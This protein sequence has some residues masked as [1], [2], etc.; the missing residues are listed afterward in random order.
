MA[1]KEPNPDNGEIKLT[2]WSVWPTWESWTWPGHEG[3][4]IQVEVYSKYPSVRLFLN[5]KLVGE[6]LTSIEQENKTTFTIPYT[7]GTLK[8][9][10]VLDNIEIESTV[11][12]TAGDPA[13]IKLIADRNNIVANGQDLSF[14]TV[15]ITDANGNIQPNA[16]NRLQFTIEGPG[17]I[18]GVDNANLKDLEKYTGSTRKA[19]NGRALVVVKSNKD[20]GS[21]RLSVDSPGLTSNHIIIKSGKN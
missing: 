11:L 6:Q 19:W 20:T 16:D 15:E 10:G 14:I 7:P 9:A 4:D 12:K 18:A 21:I 2:L 3:K 17:V 1:V 8:A 13:K 5:D